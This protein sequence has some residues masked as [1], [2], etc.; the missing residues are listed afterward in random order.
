MPWKGARAAGEPFPTLGWLVG[1]WIELNCVIPDGVHA[2]EPY[3]LTD[4]MWEFLRH[5]YRLKLDADPELPALAWECRRSQLV[6]PQKWGKGP[7]SAAMIC[8][9]ADEVDAPVLFAGW[10]K[11]GGPMG[12]PWVTPWIQVTAVSTDQ[13]DNIWRALKPMIEMGPLAARVPDTG[14]TR[15]NLPGGGF[16]EPVTA[17]AVSR[18][19]QRI[20]FC[21]H[22]ETHSWTKA[23]KMHL[24]AQTQRRN[25]S[26]MGG[27]SIETTNGWD[28]AEQSVAQ[29]TYEGKVKDVYK[30]FPRFPDA[31]KCDFAKRKRDRL[32][33]MRFAYGDSLYE[34]GGWVHLER[35]NADAEELIEQGEAAQ[36]ARFYGNL[37]VAGG[38]PAF[39]LKQWNLLA[40]PRFEVPRKEWI[41]VGFDGARYFDATAMVATHVSSGWQWPLGIWEQDAND[42]DWE[43]PVDEVYDTLESAVKYWSLHLLYADPPYW[44]EHISAWMGSYGEERIKR[45]P[46]G[47]RLPMNFALKKYRQAMRDGDV[48]H[49]GD[50][51]FSRH[52]GNARRLEY[53]GMRDDEGKPAWIIQKDRPE[54]ALKIDAAM[55]G[56]LSWMARAAA[57]DEGVL[58]RKKGAMAAF[59]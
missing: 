52:I 41:T 1:E 27:R 12:R 10:D 33:C 20:T 58:N 15:I 43:V 9:E 44:D 11:N 26:G 29:K 28:P 50:E 22:D 47:R 56:C 45:W 42:P 30:D 8:A 57:V 31:A 53:P 24:L 16:I 49:N 18:L 46:T 25:L 2:G 5:H 14:E 38:G 32:R 17:S 59:V 36:A 34:R 39:D 55:A 37:I 35:I 23:N 13:T 48:S 54:S 51:V 40:R 19:G 6:R 7:F 4:E 3:L 21:V